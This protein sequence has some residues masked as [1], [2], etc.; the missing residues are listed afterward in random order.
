MRL[1]GSS[2]ALAEV[3]VL[4][5]CQRTRSVAKRRIDST[6]DQVIPSLDAHTRG[7]FSPPN[8]CARAGDAFRRSSGSHP[9]IPHRTARP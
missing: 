9:R 1:V 8:D 6:C 4:P 3:D 5:Q 7:R 2:T